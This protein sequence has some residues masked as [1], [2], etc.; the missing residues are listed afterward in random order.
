MTTSVIA[1]GAEQESASQK[2]SMG[3]P[4][5]YGRQDGVLTFRNGPMRQNAS[6]GAADISD[7]TLELAWSS[8]TGM[9]AGEGKTIYQGS[10]WTGQPLIVKWH[11]EIRELMNLKDSKKSITGL[12]EVILPAMDGKIYFLDLDD[13]KP[14]RDP[15]ELG[16][17]FRAT[18][19]VDTSGYPML[20]AGQGISQL[21]S[22]TGT[23]GMR[24]YNLI[25]QTQI[26][27]ESGR[28][29]LAN[30]SSG[31]VD[32]SALLERDSNTLVYTGENGLLYTIGLNTEFDLAEGTLKIDPETVAYR[33]K[34]NLKGTQGIV[35]SVAMYGNYAYFADNL[36][37]LQCVDLNTMECLWAVDVT[38]ATCSTVALEDE[39]DGTIALYTAN[40]IQ[41]RERSGDVSIRRYDALTGVLEWEYTIKCKYSSDNT[42][43]A[44][45]SPVVGQ[46]DI[47]DMVVYTINQTGEEEMASVIALDKLT[48]EELWNQPLDAYSY[49]SPTA[50]YTTDGK[51]Y[52]VQGDTNGTLRLMDGF[53]GSTLSTVA[54][55]S[56]IV[57]SPAAYNDMVVV[58]TSTGR[59]C[60]IKLK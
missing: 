30:V 34:S 49:S 21:R 29:A 3:N 4:E 12:K 32:S 37:V 38:D 31:A 23:I 9:V 50:V 13:G 53:T 2:I 19:A 44:M 11:K 46:G 35:S 56:P 40:T 52:I 48:G 22:N 45:S 16:Y 15:I 27:F 20:F 39:G 6:F 43:G 54:L 25:D 33:Y 28:N 60:G 24:V 1:N 59:I 47:S 26:Y 8:K 55:G 7:E 5:E 57:G 18:A 58:G 14:T 10:D 41:K 36:G 42:A 51:G 17:P